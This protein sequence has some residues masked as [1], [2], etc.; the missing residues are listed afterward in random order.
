MP[1]RLEAADTPKEY[2]MSNVPGTPSWVDLAS[3][4]LEASRT[5]YEELFG[6]QG[7]V[8]PE[9]EAGGYTLFT[10][11]GKAVAGAGSIMDPGQPPAWT[12]YVATDDADGVAARVE[13]AGGKVLAAPMDVLDYGRMAIFADQAG[14]V[15]AVWQAKQMGG[16]EVF[17]VPGALTWNELTTRDAAGS[18][19]FYPAVLGWTPND[20]DMGDMGTYTDWMLG[21][22]RIAGMMPMVGDMWPAE[23]PNHWMI[24][25]AVADTDEAADKVRAMGGAVPVPPTDIPPGRFA[26]VSDPH[27]AHFSII[28]LNPGAAP[29]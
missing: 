13:T 9:P 15:F 27:G 25:F 3:P 6:W 7:N 5:F 22:K 26:V 14:A 21:S 28:K 10:L 29:S 11:D 18:K 16:G 1:R 23:L 17:N 12:T 8:A 4:D 2:D 20:L 19:E 24:Y